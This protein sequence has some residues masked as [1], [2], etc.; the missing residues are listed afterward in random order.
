MPAA[1]R[2]S[3]SSDVAEWLA[4]S[5]SAAAAAA[6]TEIAAGLEAAAVSVAAAAETGATAGVE[7]AASLSTAAAAA[8]V[9]TAGSLDSSSPTTAAPA[10]A[11]VPVPTSLIAGAQADNIEHVVRGMCPELQRLLATL[12]GILLSVGRRA[13]ASE[14]GHRLP[15]HL[16]AWLKSNQ[17]RLVALL[18]FFPRDFAIHHIGLGLYIEYLHPVVQANHT[19]LLLRQRSRDPSGLTLPFQ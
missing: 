1:S 8:T 5:L 18:R 15:A 7:A 9:M 10:A 16:Q 14:L 4:D 6:E 3:S 2:D 12:A 13:S 19:P 17:L 11:G